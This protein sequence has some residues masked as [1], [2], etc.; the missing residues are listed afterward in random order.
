MTTEQKQEIAVK[1][2]D[3]LA[4]ALDALWED[5]EQFTTDDEFGQEVEFN[6]GLTT[7]VKAQVLARAGE[8][9]Q[10]ILP[11]IG[12]HCLSPDYLQRFADSH[13]QGARK[14]LQEKCDEVTIELRNDI[15]EV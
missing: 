8:D 1:M 5:S 3:H 13:C 9:V 6:E 10:M 15:F 14:L 2:L 11:L 7:P 4:V 12:E